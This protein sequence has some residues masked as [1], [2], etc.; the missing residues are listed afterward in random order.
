MNSDQ[1]K[2]YRSSKWLKLRERVLYRDGYRCVQCQKPATEVEL[3]VH[4]LYYT[5]GKKAWEY[6]EADLIT[7]CKGCH[8]QV[9]GKEMPQ[10]G[11]VYEGME[12][13]GDL[14]GTCDFCGTN[15]RYVHYI[16]HEQWGHTTLTVGAHCA[17]KL[18]ESSVA[19]EKEAERKKSA[20]NL[21]TFI[22]PQKWK[23]I[24]NG[25]KRNYKQ[26]KI[27]IWDN[28]YYYRIDV[29]YNITDHWGNNVQKPIKG[30]DRFKTLEEA[31]T[32]V[33]EKINNGEVEEYIKR[34][35]NED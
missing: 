14:I 2:S 21:T 9:H 1:K 16:Y 23:I 7:L 26:Y 18:T 20:R 24:K 31:K 10:F 11:W 32:K 12:D 28:H 4:H 27:F 35:A 34:H 19:S 17:D 8:A 5:E 29:Y 22:N 33:F 13:L 6:P 30:Q 3:Q 15:I 25:I